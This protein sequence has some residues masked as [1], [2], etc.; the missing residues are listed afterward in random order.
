MKSFDWEANRSLVCDSTGRKLTVGLFEEL[1]DSA[2]TIKPPFKLA[3]WRKVYVEIADPNDYKAALVLIGNWDHWQMLLGCKSFAAELE[4]WRHEVHAKLRSDAIA[5]L[6]KQSKS[7][8]GTAAAKVLLDLGAEP[9]KRG[10]PA[11]DEEQQEVNRAGQ[12][13]RRLGLITGGKA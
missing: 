2:A 11:K 4:K 7:D 13:A 3:D 8:K 1:A 10:R 9:K 12:D 6:V 5:Q